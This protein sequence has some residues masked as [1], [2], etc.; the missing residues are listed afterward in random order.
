MIL[1]GKEIN[2]QV[3]NGVIRIDPFNTDQ[4]NPNSY[5]LRLH[6]DLLVYND[7]VLDMKEKNT[8]SPLTI[9]EDGL[10]L[11]PQKLYLGRTIERTA[12]D[13]YVPMLEGRSSVGRL[14]LFI[15]ITAGFGDIGFDGFW[16]LEIFC[17]QPIKIYSAL[18]IC[19][20]FYHT[21]DGDYDLYQSKKYQ[22]NQ[23]VQPSKLYK[24]F[25][26]E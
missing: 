6:S 12:T 8:T 20:I 22:G 21:I 23:G 15:H 10:L 11:E 2:K 9:P 7:N 14:G 13:K 16:T 26:K 1:S 24:D 17:V 4:L 18:E 25:E 3:E 19:Q 5:N